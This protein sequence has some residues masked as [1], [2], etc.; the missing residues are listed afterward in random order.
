MDHGMA[1]LYLS[2]LLPPYGGDISSY[3][4]CNAVNYVDFHASI[5]TYADTF[6]LSTIQ[7]WNNRPGSVRSADTLK[8]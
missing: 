3:R 8:D 6:L 5:Q 7:T 2:T 1:P 4:L